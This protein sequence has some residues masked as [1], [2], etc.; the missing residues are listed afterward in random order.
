MSHEALE[1]NFREMFSSV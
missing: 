1:F